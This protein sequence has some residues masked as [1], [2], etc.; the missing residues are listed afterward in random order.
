[1][2]FVKRK[3]ELKKLALN[4]GSKG[5][6]VYQLIDS[7]KIDHIINKL[8]DKITLTNTKV[9]PNT[10]KGYLTGNEQFIDIFVETLHYY[11]LSFAFLDNKEEYIELLLLNNTPSFLYAKKYWGN[12]KYIDYYKY[13]IKRFLV[14]N[15]YSNIKSVYSNFKNF[16]EMNNINS[17]MDL[18]QEQ[19]VDILFEFML[20]L[21]RRNNGKDSIRY[22]FIDSNKLLSKSDIDSLIINWENLI[23]GYK[24]E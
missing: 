21:S 1:M 16:F 8:N 12:N 9:L 10:M 3:E 20:A 23:N 18:N 5:A 19:D 22:L 7:G 13:N 11:E 6:Y 17:K 15:M 24:R 14:E 2:E 4:A